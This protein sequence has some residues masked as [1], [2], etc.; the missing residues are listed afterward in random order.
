[1][2]FYEE[3]MRCEKIFAYNVKM[4]R[5]AKGLT[6]K[7]LA[8][9]ILGYPVELLQKVEEGLAYECN[10]EFCV[11]LAKFF[12][13]S[14]DDLLTN[15]HLTNIMILLDAGVAIEDDDSYGC[16]GCCHYDNK[17]CGYFDDLTCHGDEVKAFEENCMGCCCGDG[18]EC[19]KG[20]GGC[21]NY[22]TEPVMG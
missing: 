15:R 1:M 6:Q 14:L 5:E 12:G 16:T 21:E 22:E 9:E 18:C 20:N 2:K 11:S 8:V 19:N 4:C 7:E 17:N 13:F 10:L 3:P